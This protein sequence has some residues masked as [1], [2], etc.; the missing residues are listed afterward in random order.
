MEQVGQRFQMVLA[1]VGD[2]VEVGGVVARQHPE[3]DVL[4]EALGDAP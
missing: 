2:G 3:G 1:E 4:V